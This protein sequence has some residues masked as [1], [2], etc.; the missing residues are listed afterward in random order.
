[1]TNFCLLQQSVRMG[2]FLSLTTLLYLLVTSCSGSPP[3]N[4]I[5]LFADDLGFGDLGCYGHPTSLT[6]NLDRL[7]ADGL[8]FTDFY[9]T[10]PVCSPSR[11]SL[12][13]GRYQTRSGVYPGVFYPG[14]RGGLPLNETTIAEMLKPLG[15]A[16]A[17]MGKW[18]L[19]VGE[20]GMY[21][22][23]Q[24]GFDHYL[25]VPYSHDMGPCQNL[26]CFPPDVKCFGNCDVG[27]VTI[28]LMHNDVI[29][30]QPVDF[31]D[32]ERA[33]SDFA[34]DFITQST[35]KKQ[36]FFLYYPSHHT[37]YPQY[38]G[39]ATAGRSRR[40]PFGDALLEFDSTVGNLLSAL[41]HTGVLNNTLILF[42]ADNG[43]ELMRMSRGGNA[44]PLK[45]GK[46]TTYEGGMREPAI[47]YWPG[48]I[49][50]GV[51]HELASTLDIMPT[52]AG[53]AGAKLPMVQLDGVDMTDI[54]VNH[55]PSKREAMM[56]YPTDPSEKYG[57]FALRL[58]KYKAHF[59]T[60]GAG[61][62]ETTPDQDCHIISFLKPHDP[63]L[64]FDLESDPSEN[65]PLSPLGR[66]DLQALLQRIGVVKK[67]FEASMVFG[68]SQI[69]KGSDPDLEPCCTPHCTPKPSCCQCG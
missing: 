23:T 68:E 47:A 11:A 42:T 21:L 19:G 51:T 3:S 6:P 37:H 65:Y 14:S 35:R 28:P 9:C 45:C 61:H 66:P 40:G 64:L 17:A 56:F 31:L 41:E 29:K 20:N 63:P 27:V 50:P 59:Y 24:Q 7:A 5:L 52:I 34:T 26:T 55:G 18:H 22:P 32:L 54:L 8:R 69:G 53:L 13:T 25:G 44:G 1:M 49:T 12:L 36:P 57:L 30:Q 43:P 38:A 67:Q 58:G 33:Y 10:S 2:H 62:S 15:Y 60:R 39:P 48:T 46:G 16:T 4:F